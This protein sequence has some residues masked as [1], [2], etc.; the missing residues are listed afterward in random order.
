MAETIEADVL[1]FDLEDA[2][3]PEKKEAARRMTADAVADGKYR[4][5]ELIIRINGLDTKWA[6]GDIAAATPATPHGILVPKVNRAEDIR[7][8]RAALRAAGAD[9]ETMIWAMMETPQAILNA[10]AIASAGADQGPTLG[11]LVIGTNDLAA[12]T[13]VRPARDRSPM[14]PWLSTCV[15][16]ARANDLAVIDGIYRDFN[17]QDGFAGECG[18]ARMLGMDGKSLIHPNQVAVCNSIFTPSADEIAW[19]KSVLAAFDSAE[20]A[21]AHS[22]TV[23]GRIVERLHARIARR[24]MTIA[25]AARRSEAQLQSAAAEDDA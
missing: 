1:I 21:G 12:E 16:A 13:E 2:V 9:P 3:P 22:V 8:V 5:K 11:G 7:R 19:A 25:K 24:M 23:D 14:I 4:G 15:L 20:N 17:D 10:A 18:Q 6:A